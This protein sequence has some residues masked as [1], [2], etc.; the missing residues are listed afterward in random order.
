M[1]YN[2]EPQNNYEPWSFV[3]SVPFPKT[4]VSQFLMPPLTEFFREKRI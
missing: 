4:Q 1:W 3:C 2:V